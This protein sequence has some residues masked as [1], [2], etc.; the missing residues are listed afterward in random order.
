MADK[1]H[2]ALP[3]PSIPGS[4][5]P[6]GVSVAPP[7]WPLKAKLW[8]FLYRSASEDPGAGYRV[9]ENPNNVEDVLQGLPAGAYHPME[10]VHPDALKPVDGKPQGS[11]GMKSV[12]IVRYDDTPVGP[13]DELIL[14]PGAFTN[15]HT[16]K[17][18]L[19]ITNIYVSTDKSAFN[20]RSNW[21]IGKHIARFEFSP[22]PGHARDEIVK[23]FH[24]DDSPLAS[25]LAPA[26]FFTAVLTNSRIPALPVPFNISPFTIVQPPL[27]P[28]RYEEG[29]MPSIIG[30]DD[31]VNGRHNPWLE[32][33]PIYKGRWQLSYISALPEEEGGLPRHGDGVGYPMINPISAGAVFTGH[34][35]FPSS[36]IV[37][38]GK[39]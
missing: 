29:A 6:P 5:P 15:P 10:V 7:P 3:D 39:A 31:S 17:R 18:D 14:I 22:R 11:G 34:I 16:G 38:G 21:N 28:P 20:G 37:G 2:P 13:Y 9:E 30:T 32:T 27:L 33:P 36:T 35:D 25:P 19:R 24:P 8:T 23:V 4:Q 1:F 26:P 12:V